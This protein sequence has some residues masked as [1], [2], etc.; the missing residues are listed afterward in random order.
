MPYSSKSQMRLFFA[1]EKRGELPKGTAKEWAHET[2]S[3]K[4]LPQYKGKRKRTR[5]TR[6][7]FVKK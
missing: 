6:K 3:I 7:N 2:K 5:I 1:K 4:S